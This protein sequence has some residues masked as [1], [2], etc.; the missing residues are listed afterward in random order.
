MEFLASEGHWAGSTGF[1]TLGV[2]LKYII[3]IPHSNCLGCIFI[4]PNLCIQLHALQRFY[5]GRSTRVL[6]V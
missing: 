6:K 5:R 2:E 1:D 3:L 4:V